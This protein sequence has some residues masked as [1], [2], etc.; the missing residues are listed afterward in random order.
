MQELA[1][2]SFLA[3]ASQPVF[4]DDSLVASDVAER[5]GG[6]HLADGSHIELTHRS[7]GLVH[8]RKRQR[9]NPGLIGESNLQVEGDVGDRR[10]EVLHDWWNSDDLLLAEE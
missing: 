10:N 9:H 8:S 7:S 3:E 6:S 1:A 2:V 4:A 5:A